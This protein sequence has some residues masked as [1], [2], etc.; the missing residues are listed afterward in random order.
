MNGVG[1]D[2]ACYADVS[3]LSKFVVVLFLHLAD[4]SNSNILAA[5]YDEP[6]AS[7]PH[8]TLFFVVSRPMATMFGMPCLLTFS[9]HRYYIDSTFNHVTYVPNHRR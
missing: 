1:T 4:Q 7:F 8:R 5:S 2:G 6:T 9:S 3:R